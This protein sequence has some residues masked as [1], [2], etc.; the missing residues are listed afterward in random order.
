M[1][2]VNGSFAILARELR[3]LR[4]ASFSSYVILTSLSLS[5]LQSNKHNGLARPGLDG[6][7]CSSDVRRLFESGFRYHNVI[8]DTGRQSRITVHLRPVCGPTTST[9]LRKLRMFESPSRSS[10]KARW[11]SVTSSGRCSWSASLLPFSLHRI[12]D[13]APTQVLGAVSSGHR[14]ERPRFVCAVP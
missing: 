4:A 7:I 9:V 3:C 12:S 13:L 1:P 5:G 14:N 6:Y 2:P 11:W 8:S 10:Y